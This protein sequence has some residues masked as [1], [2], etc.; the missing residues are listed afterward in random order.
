MTCKIMLCM[1]VLDG[2][3]ERWMT[4]HTLPARTSLTHL[5]SRETRA[6][7]DYEQYVGRTALNKTK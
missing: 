3:T 2:W 5:N 6:S 7:N 4:T 1:T